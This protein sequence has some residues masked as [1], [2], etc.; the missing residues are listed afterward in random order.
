MYPHKAPQ[1][2]CLSP[3]FHPNI[4]PENGLVYLAILATAWR[5]V[6]TIYEILLAIQV[7][8]ARVACSWYVLPIEIRNSG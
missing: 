5:P 2:K 4:H 6:L 7:G 8:L 3:I 1:V